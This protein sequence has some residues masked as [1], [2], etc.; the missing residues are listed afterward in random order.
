MPLAPKMFLLFSKVLSLVL[1]SLL[2]TIAVAQEDLALLR[3]VADNYRALKSFEFIGHLSSTIPGTDLQFRVPTKDAEAGSI[4]VPKHTQ[5]LK[6]GETVEFHSGT[7][8]DATGKPTPPEALKQGVIMPTNFGH[9]DEIALDIVSTNS[10]PSETL[11]LDGKPTQCYV[12][13]VVYD[14]KRRKP[15]EQIVRYWIDAKTLLVLKQNF[16]QWQKLDFN[17]V[18]WHWTYS[19]DSISVGQPPPKWLIES[20]KDR[21]NHPQSHPEWIGRTAPDFNLIDLSGQPVHSSDLRGKVVL[22]DFWST[23]CGPCLDEIPTVLE[24][25]SEYKSKGLE[26]WGVS[27]EPASD[28]KESFSTNKWIFPVLLDPDCRLADQFQVVGIPAIILIGRDGKV[29]SYFVGKQSEQSLR[30]LIDSALTP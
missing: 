2:G 18:V 1:I 17:E 10:L 15:E 7:V 21:I 4:F 11:Q 27:D 12:L 29:L 22:M 28:I 6:Y 14:R 5:L 30:G 26:T 19:I 8:I 9:Y 24:L 3:R 25:A 16:A 23:W 20:S 13:D